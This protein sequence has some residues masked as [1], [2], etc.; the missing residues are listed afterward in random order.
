MY[1]L[2]D[3]TFLP[4]SSYFQNVLHWFKHM[5]I[6]GRKVRAVGRGYVRSELLPRGRALITDAHFKL[7]GVLSKKSN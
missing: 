3:I 6:R 4:T 7:R 2:V 5:M 1:K